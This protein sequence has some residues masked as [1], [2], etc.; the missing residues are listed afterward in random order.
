MVVALVYCILG[1]RFCWHG[2][3]RRGISFGF[4]IRSWWPGISSSWWRGIISR[5]WFSPSLCGIVGICG[6]CIVGISGWLQTTR[7][8]S[9]S[10]W[11]G[12]HWCYRFVSSWWNITTAGERRIGKS[13]VYGAPRG[14]LS[15]GNISRLNIDCV[16]I[17]VNIVPR[18]WKPWYEHHTR[19][20]MIGRTHAHIT[21]RDRPL[22][23]LCFSLGTLSFFISRA[24]TST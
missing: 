23:S 3:G 10:C 14:R 20:L 17:D 12:D 9:I 22:C 7:I 19:P 15:A 4:A 24:M 2:G 16:I 5:R 6:W 11:I 13:L 8:K 1:G 21:V 18:N